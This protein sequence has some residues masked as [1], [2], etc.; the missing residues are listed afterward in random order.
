MLDKNSPFAVT[1]RPKREENL[2]SLAR[3]LIGNAIVDCDLA[4]GTLTSEVDLAARFAVGLAATRS[5]LARLAAAGWIAA[6]GRKGWR[7]LPI[8]GEHLS[9]LQASRACLEP[10]LIGQVPP[11]PLRAE[12]RQRAALY[13]ANLPGLGAA[14]RFHQEREL[15]AL[16]A[17][18]MAGPRLRGWLLDTWDL[19]MRADRFIERSFGIDRPALPLAHLAE[20][21]AEADGTR[22]GQQL[23][24]MREEFAARCAR[25]LARS[26][27]QIAALPAASTPSAPVSPRAPLAEAAANKR[28]AQQGDQT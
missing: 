16:C 2:S 18:V 8:S 26:D 3:I 14:A 9:D 19:S 13:R 15:L 23:C 22:A 1:G 6:E 7:V 10:V 17:G 11:A 24:A 5:A 20:A 25:A 4:P 28:T 12:L 21:L 27:A